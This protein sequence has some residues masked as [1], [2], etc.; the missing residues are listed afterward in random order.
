MREVNHAIVDSKF[1]RKSNFWRT[2]VDRSNGDLRYNSRHLFVNLAA[3][4]V[5]YDQLGGRYYAITESSYKLV[6]QIVLSRPIFLSRVIF[7][8]RTIFPSGPIFPSRLSFP[9]TAKF[10]HNGGGQHFV[11]FLSWVPLFSTF[12]MQ[13]ESNIT[14]I[15]LPSDLIS[16]PSSSST[17]LSSDSAEPSSDA[18]LTTLGADLATLD[19]DLAR[20][21]SDADL[22]TSGIRKTPPGS[23]NIVKL[24]AASG[25]RK[26]RKQKAEHVTVVKKERRQ[27]FIAEE[28]QVIMQ[29]AGKNTTVIK[30]R[31]TPTITS[32]A[33]ENV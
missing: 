5:T 14:A 3:I 21:T 13:T 27:K 32:E 6:S 1:D 7:L 4:L 9:I 28:V 16:R 11:W 26:R 33:K 25:K 29:E 10:S 31:F 2:G 17:P 8:S 12:I 18:D 22:A 19:A 24:N 15:Q 30:G 20:I 23:I